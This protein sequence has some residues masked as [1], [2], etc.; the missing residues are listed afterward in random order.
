[1]EKQEESFDGSFTDNIRS[2]GYKAQ[3]ANKKHKLVINVSGNSS[4]MPDTQYAVVKHVAKKNKWFLQTDPFTNL[5]FDICWTDNHV[6]PDLFAR[7][8]PHQ[9]INHFPGTNSAKQE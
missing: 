6:K 9:K 8:Q 2:P 3:W 5:N 4:F 7:M 1:M